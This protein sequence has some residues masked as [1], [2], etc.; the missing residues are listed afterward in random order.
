MSRT[1]AA[2]ASS[3]RGVVSQA[4]DRRHLVAPAL[5]TCTRWGDMGVRRPTVCSRAVDVGDRC[6]HVGGVG[7]ERAGP[8]IGPGIVTR[9]H[10]TKSIHPP[11]KPAGAVLPVTDVVPFN[12]RLLIVLTPPPA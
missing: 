10:N 6:R 7:A 1:H 9:A 8:G 3:V 5:G 2:I 12:S 4:M 11:L